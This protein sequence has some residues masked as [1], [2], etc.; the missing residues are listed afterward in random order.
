VKCRDARAFLSRVNDRGP[1]IALIA[2][3]DLDFLVSN[4]YVRAIS[5]DDYSKGVADVARLSQLSDQVDT[6]KPEVESAINELEE[7]KQKT[8]AFL[9]HFEGRQGKEEVEQK[10][11]TEQATVSQESTQLSALE[12]NLNQLIQEKSLIDRAVPYGEGYIALT[13]VGT[14]VLNDLNVR[15]YRVDDEEFGEFVDEIRSTY[16][17]LRSIADRAAWY[18]N[19][20]KPLVPDLGSVTDSDDPSEVRSPSLLWSVA[21]GLG[22]L[23]GDPRETGQ[24]FVQAFQALAHLDATVPNKLMAAEIMTAL[25]GPDTALLEASLSDIDK[26][27]RGQGVPRELSAGVAA[28]IMAGRRFDG[29]YPIGNYNVYRGLTPSYEAAAIMAVMNLPV[30][31]V[32]GRF[33]SFRMTFT[34]WGYTSS[35]DTEVASAYLAIGELDANSVIEKMKYAVAQ[36]SNYLEYPLVA[37]AILASIP[38]FEVHEVLDLMEKAVTLLSNYAVGLERSEVV[39]LAVRMIH[40]VRNEIVKQIDP[41]APVAKTPVQFT[42][43]A[44]PGFFLW[45]SPI[46]LAHSSYF[47]S[48]SGLGG[49]HPGHSHGIGGFAG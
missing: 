2:P 24:R 25:G 48:F 14:L 19:L 22:K 28:T 31:D 12:N 5:Q 18:V 15:D 6:M 4:G 41:N 1:S 9:F 35:E 37:A 40:G 33:Q 46:I 26:S 7:E 17:E 23:Q 45:Y 8:H 39:A 30:Q 43:L 11:Q 3:V 13:G 47:A 10:I 36:L 42:Y 34:G 27:L 49:F 21:I 20:V 16:T 29:T 32:S 38:V 44:Q